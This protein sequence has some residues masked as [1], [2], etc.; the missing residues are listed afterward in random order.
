MFQM[1]ILHAL[2]FASLG[3][4]GNSAAV[5]IAVVNVPEISERYNGRVKLEEHFE[6]KRKQLTEKKDELAD[7]IK[8][9][10]QSLQ[11]ELK[12]GTPDFRSRRRELAMLEAEFQYFLDTEGKQIEREL[13]ASLRQIFDE[14]NVVIA[15]VAAQRGI[16]LVLAADTMPGGNPENPTQVRQQIVLQKVLYWNPSID[17]TDEVVARLNAKFK[18]QNP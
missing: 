13:A 7:K 10:Q 2:V 14:I 18:T 5:N 12:P 9:T 16:G 15:E 17:L 3:Q 6:A 11:E 1:S 4:S 8:R